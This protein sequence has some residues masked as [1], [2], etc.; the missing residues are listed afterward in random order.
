MIDADTREPIEGAV[1]V[2]YWLEARRTS[3]WRFELKTEGRER[4]LNGQKW[5]VVCDGPCRWRKHDLLL[6]RPH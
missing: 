3:H 6:P 1:V 4:D 2:V 5:G